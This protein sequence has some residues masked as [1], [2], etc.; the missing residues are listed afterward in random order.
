LIDLSQVPR[1]SATLL[2]GIDGAGG[3]GKSTLAATLT[4]KI[5]AMDDF[6]TAPWEWYDF[7][8]LCRDVLEPLQRD[9]PARYQRMDWNDG[10]L[11][12]WHELQPGGVVVVEGVA[13]L[14]MLLRPA[15]DYR[16]WVETPREISLERGLERDGPAALP[17][18]E[19][20]SEKEEQY[21]REQRPR[22]S[23]DA[24]VDGSGR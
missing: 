1:R 24:I 19:A 12:E 20:W 15:Y 4:D 9:E 6:I 8:R 3:S 17:L 18:W 22:E 2:V 23:A 16:I 5:V 7:E 13:A 11:R 14:D 10:E 21:W